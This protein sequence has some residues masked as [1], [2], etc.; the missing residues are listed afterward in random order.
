MERA[1]GTTPRQERPVLAATGHWR[2]LRGEMQA[3]AARDTQ[4]AFPQA[5]TRAALALRAEARLSVLMRLSFS[6]APVPS[7]PS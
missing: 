5:S 2:K 7:S 1:G 3:A 6:P 4:A